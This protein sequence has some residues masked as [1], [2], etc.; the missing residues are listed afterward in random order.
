M[1]S[2]ATVPDRRML[3]DVS[4][5]WPVRLAGT[6]SLAAATAAALLEFALTIGARDRGGEFCVACTAWAGCDAAGVG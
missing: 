1:G 2:E 5:V 6:G 4:R 3:S